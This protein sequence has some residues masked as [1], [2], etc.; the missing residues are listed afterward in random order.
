MTLPNPSDLHDAAIVIVAGGAST[1]MGFDKAWADLG[2]QPLLARSLATARALRPA[3]LVLVVAES[4]LPEARRLAP[5]ACVVAGGERRRD[6]VANG[7]AASTAPWVA[8]HDAARAL[9]E[10]RL[11]V[12]GFLHA[13]TTGAALP[14]LPVK[15]TIKHVREGRVHATLVRADHVLVQTP[16][17]FDRRLL[18]RAL[19]A[20]ED[21]VTD[22]ATLVERLGSVVTIFPGDERNFKITTP[23]DLALARWLVSDRASG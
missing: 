1:R 17:V 12:E 2:G 14:A 8:I 16:Q 21:D 3:E 11:F 20:S 5:D 23:F 9:V 7:V 4:R 22:E 6:S 15:D 18:A 13:R 10:A 19:A